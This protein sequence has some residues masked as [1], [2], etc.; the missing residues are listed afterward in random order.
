MPCCDSIMDQS[1]QFDHLF[2][3]LSFVNLFAAVRVEVSH[4]GEQQETGGAEA[5]QALAFDL[6]SILKIH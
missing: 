1:T 2:W 5:S 4:V 6:A 3:G